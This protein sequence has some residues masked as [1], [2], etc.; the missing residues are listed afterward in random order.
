VAP[1]KGGGIAKASPQNI[2]YWDHE[3]GGA[4]NQDSGLDRRKWKNVTLVAKSSGGTQ[5]AGIGRPG[6]L[7][8]EDAGHWTCK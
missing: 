6:D 2:S 1:S 5:A 7:R 3:M 8:R 4:I